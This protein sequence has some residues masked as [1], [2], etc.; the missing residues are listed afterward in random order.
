LRS[1]HFILTRV[2]VIEF[3][4]VNAGFFFLAIGLCFGFLSGREHLALAQAFVSSPTL[5]LIP[6]IIWG[7]YTVKVIQYNRLEFSKTENNF[8]YH[9]AS[10]TTNQLW[11][12]CLSVAFKQFNLPFLYAIFL[13][14]VALKQQELDSLIE[15]TGVFISLTVVVGYKLRAEVLHPG[16]NK[17]ISLLKNKID[18]W[19][20]RQHIWFYPEWILRQQPLMV[21]GTK[22]FSGLLIIGVSRLYLFDSYDERLM[23]MGCTLAFSSNLA[24]VYF[25]HRF[26]SLHFNLMR[27]L[28][29]PLLKRL[30]SFMVTMILLNIVEA[31]LI[32]NYYPSP[33]SAYHC[34]ELL[35]FGLSI[36]LLALAVLYIKSVEMEKFIQYVFTASFS[37]FILI[38][39]KMPVILLAVFQI[40]IAFWIYSKN[41]YRFEYN[42]DPIINKKS[43]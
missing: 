29:I 11:I 6:F 8:L 10:L 16:L 19:F 25:Y 21:I 22:I 38:L 34:V 2:L 28:P 3:Y 5:L 37:W 12:C 23:A 35:L 30:N 24:L 33:L 27:S 14:I 39:F 15:I 17:K 26:D 40:L 41:Y 32:F 1:L 42:S 36:Y 20:V 4:K 9:C 43:N 7:L 31:G 18:S 13:S